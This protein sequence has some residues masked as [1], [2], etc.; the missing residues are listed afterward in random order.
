MPHAR[1]AT[2]F[3]SSDQ[4]EILMQAALYYLM[5][6]LIRAVHTAVFPSHI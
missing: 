6:P 2:H 5:P 1:A 4:G 3:M